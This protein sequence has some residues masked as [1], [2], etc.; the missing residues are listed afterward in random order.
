MRPPTEA[1][2]LAAVGDNKAEK[3]AAK[4]AD[5]VAATN[6]AKS[7]PTTVQLSAQINM[8]S[9]IAGKYESQVSE[10]L[11]NVRNHVAENPVLY[12][13]HMRTAGELNSAV[14]ARPINCIEYFGNK[15]HHHEPAVISCSSEDAQYVLHREPLAYPLLIQ[16]ERAKVDHR[17][18]L[19]FFVTCFS[20]G[21]QLVLPFTSTET[22]KIDKAMD[23]AAAVAAF[24]QGKGL[25]DRWHPY[26]KGK[27]GAPCGDHRPGARGTRHGSSWSRSGS[28]RACQH[29][30][31][32]HAGRCAR[33]HH[34]RPDQPRHVLDL[35]C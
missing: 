1:T 32:I 12:S 30:I 19:E 33:L 5:Q 18:P 26:S 2:K 35:L 14:A 28:W 34:S 24:Q 15:P 25:I 8:F 29:L 7:W 27:S 11:A 21:D 9:A 20:V 3:E 10:L 6:K 16:A 4:V 31:Y 17:I 22:G 23:K 13:Q